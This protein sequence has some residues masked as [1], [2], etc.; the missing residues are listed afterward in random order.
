MIQID[1]KLISLDVIEQPFACDLSVCKG[2]CCVKGDSGAPLEQD[3]VVEIEKAWPIVKEYLRDISVKSI[4]EQGFAVI[5]DD[6]DLVT[7]LVNGEECAYTIFE[8]G[9]AFC[10]I[11]KAFREKK[12]NFRK[13]I[14]C[15]LYPIRL[16]ELKDGVAV[17]YHHWNICEAARKNGREKGCYVYQFAS[18]ALE[19]KFGKEWV[20]ELNHSAEWYFKEYV[21]RSK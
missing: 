13:P 9:I 7:P 5:D 21:K 20:E 18:E 1:D 14:S 3:E 19:R 11:E 8:E 2:A 10:G 16:S 17:N 4:E 12:I 6:G 15:H